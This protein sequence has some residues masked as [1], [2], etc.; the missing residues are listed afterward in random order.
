MRASLHTIRNSNECKSIRNGSGFGNVE[1]EI[2]KQRIQIKKNKTKERLYGPKLLTGNFKN[3]HAQI[4]LIFVEFLWVFSSRYLSPKTKQIELIVFAIIYLFFLTF[5]QNQFRHARSVCVI[6]TVC[7]ISQHV[8]S[9]VR[10]HRIDADGF[11]S[12]I[13]Q[14]ISLNIIFVYFI[15]HSL[16]P[17][18]QAYI[19]SKH[20]L[21]V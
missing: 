8:V 7:R 19:K 14:S 18:Q 11:D 12:Y 3:I 1:V 21:Y 2:L 4:A 6:C 13:N 17:Y 9:S 5:F 15:S 10:R 16:T 20:I